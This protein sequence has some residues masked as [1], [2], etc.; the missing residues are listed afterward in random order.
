MDGGTSERGEVFQMQAAS[1]AERKRCF[2]ESP[3][4]KRR[5]E[6]GILVTMIVIVWGLF[7]L[8]IVFYYDSSSKVC[9]YSGV[10]KGVVLSVAYGVKTLAAAL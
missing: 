8:P 10:L 5:L 7:L 2:L 4:W 1:S 3:D 9:Y 6:L